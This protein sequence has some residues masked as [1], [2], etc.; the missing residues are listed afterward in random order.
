[1]RRKMLCAVCTLGMMS[2]VA[3]VSCSPR[4]GGANQTPGQ[5]SPFQQG[6][7]LTRCDGQAVP[8]ATAAPPSAPM[9]AY[10]GAVSTHDL[11][12]YLY[13]FAPNDGSTRWCNRFTPKEPPQ[14]CPYRSCPGP[15]SVVPGRPLVANGVVYVCVSGYGGFTYAFNTSNGLLRWMQQ[16]DC[17]PGSIPFGDYA[18]P[19]LANGVL[20]TGKD[21]LN[22]QNGR[23]LWRLSL[24]ATFASVVDGT[25]YAYAEAMVYALNPANG[26]V[27]WKYQLGNVIACL[28]AVAD[29]TVYVGEQNSVGSDTAVTTALSA[30][31]GSVLWKYH[32][33]S[34]SI[35]AAG[36]MVYLGDTD[37]I[38]A[39]DAPGGQLRWHFP[40]TMSGN[41]VSAVLD[42]MVYLSADGAYALSAS[43]GS[44]RWHNMLGADQS[45]WFSTGVVMDETFYLVGTDGMGNSTLFALRLSDGSARWQQAGIPQMTP[46]ALG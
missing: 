5:Q 16:T 1:M 45:H 30:S 27:R 11:E 36:G 24:D 26:S 23:V 9:S 29:G 31:T 25:L 20:Y 8:T 41:A 42:G 34:F 40:I 35:V 18:A 32:A 15:S 2:L 19:V 4:P 17:G 44:K 21:A 38:T 14:G 6:Y 10:V 12:G 13:A 33:S 43:D 7:I 37:G 3:L 46:P 28:P 22:A 39:L